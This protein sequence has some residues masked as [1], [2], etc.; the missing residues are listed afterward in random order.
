MLPKIERTDSMDYFVIVEFSNGTVQRRG[1][2]K[3]ESSAVELC[4]DE[5]RHENVNTAYVEAR[6]TEKD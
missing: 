2:F 6:L 3:T 5:E 4:D 1:P